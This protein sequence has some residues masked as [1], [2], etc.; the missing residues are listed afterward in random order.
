MVESSKII[1][2]K[3]III[4]ITSY[5]KTLNFGLSKNETEGVDK[6][7]GL[8]QSV[9]A[10]Q[11]WHGNLSLF[12][13]L[14]DQR[15]GSISSLCPVLICVVLSWKELKEISWCIHLTFSRKKTSWL[16][17]QL[18]GSHTYCKMTHF[19]SNRPGQWIEWRRP[20]K[21]I[22]NLAHN[23][24]VSAKAKIS[25]NNNSNTQCA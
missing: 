5:N 24:M 3:E 21:G 7:G 8:R 9:E 22:D 6:H 10:I 13:K 25:T 23:V 16:S 15:N 4:I 19:N 17:E 20:S 14:H 2:S 11:L 1:F 18:S 12:K